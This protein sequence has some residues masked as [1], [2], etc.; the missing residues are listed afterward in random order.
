VIPALKNRQASAIELAAQMRIKHCSLQAIGARRS[1][2]PSKTTGVEAEAAAPHQQQH[3][4]LPARPCLSFRALPSALLLL[5][6]RL[7][8]PFELACSCCTSNGWDQNVPL[9]G[10]VLLHVHT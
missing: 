9:A 6:P 7:Y 5:F 3:S 4:Q 2:A 8:V 10:T 1:I